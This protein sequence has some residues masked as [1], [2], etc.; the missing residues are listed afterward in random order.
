M[1]HGK[2]SPR[3]KMINMMYLVLTA[4][5]ALN[6]SAE[7]LNAF[8]L[9]DNSLVK[10]ANNIDEKNEGIHT[11]FLKAFEENKGKVGPWK[12]K[13]D[14]VKTKSKELVDYITSLQE[15]IV[16]IGDGTDA[17]YKEHGS[18][19]IAKKDDTNSP[20]QVLILEKKGVELKTKIET[21]R[22]LLKTY[23]K[24][25]VGK[26]NDGLVASLESS[27]STAD[28][29]GHEGNM[30][31]WELA[32]FEHLPLAGVITML[33]KMKT[34]I[35]TAEANVITHLFGQ[36]DAGSFKFNKIEAI[37]RAEKGFVLQG[38]EY[39][40]EVFIAASDTTKEPT[41][42]LDNGTK[43]KIDT[44]TGKGVFIAR[45]GAGVH[46]LKGQ[47][48]L[49]NPSG[50]DTLKYDFQ[51]E[52]QVAVPSVSVSPTKM[53]VFYIGVDNPVDITAAGVNP[54]SVNAS[55]VGNGSIAK[56]GAGYI[57]KVRGGAKCSI[58]VS[59][60]GKNL[61][62]KEF[63]IKTVPDPAAVVGSDPKN[64]KGGQ[65]A[66]ATLAGMS[67]VRAELENFDFQLTFSVTTFDVTAQVGG[68]YETEKASS[69]AFTPRQKGLINKLNRNDRVFIENV[70]AVGPDGTPR[71]LNDIV[72]KLQ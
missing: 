39:K 66:K 33:T 21:F 30:I 13:A 2:T 54:N 19:A 11:E 23:S 25:K 28:I 42:L 72:F 61:G 57:V 22:E 12:E 50:E 8:V 16:K 3:Q 47:I 37:V 51:T 49:K 24:D 40:A 69:G 55:F 36:V 52:Y 41:I 43:L 46:K 70:R 31:P 18:S 1:G 64:K 9:V 59:A 35:K 29:K 6:V 60:D 68:F 63:R 14:E 53:N 26:V 10:T 44:A 15:Q 5:L 4:L 58:N 67:G 65:I 20:S 34:D 45:S 48:R 38:E 62:S 32:N 56:S 17:L 71:K 7:I 27:L